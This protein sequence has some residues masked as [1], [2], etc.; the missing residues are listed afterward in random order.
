[1]TEVEWLSSNDPR[2]MLQCLIGGFDPCIGVRDS[3]QP[4]HAGFGTAT[5]R[6]LR[7][8][9]CAC[10]RQVWDAKPCGRCNEC[11]GGTGG[12]CCHNVG[13]LTD[14]R[15]RRAV[16]VA[17][18]FA[19]GEATEQEMRDAIQGASNAHA[20]MLRACVPHERRMPAHAAQ[21]VAPINGFGPANIVR[22]VMQW[23]SGYQ[24]IQTAATQAA[25]LREIV[26]NPFQRNL[27]WEETATRKQLVQVIRRLKLPN[28]NPHYVGETLYAPVLWLTPNVLALAA[29]AYDVANIA[30]LP[31]RGTGKEAPYEC[32]QGYSKAAS[33]KHCGGSGS[34]R[35]PFDAAVLP[36]LSDALEDA[37][38]ADEGM[39]RHL[40]G[41]EPC[42]ELWP[43]YANPAYPQPH[44][45]YGPIT[46]NPKCPCGG[47]GWR[48][49]TCPHVRG[50][51]VVD[52]IL[53]KE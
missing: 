11:I 14:P 7:L 23:L 3:N 17:E 21:W 29:A 16:E 49:S 10:C 46:H 38:C 39:L 42:M 32:G 22:E 34:G 13:G 36:R 44:N 31:C 45:H 27:F 50:C 20:D 28:Q 25:L 18:R 51:W 24:E 6:K 19:D 53:G 8:F 35:T 30:C 12:K 47:S 43:N 52:L 48:K 33:C 26:G 37:G 1:M 40:R 15:S 5:D 2:R 9:A 4:R 41:E